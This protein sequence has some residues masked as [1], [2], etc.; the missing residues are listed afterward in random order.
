MIW[1]LKR[2]EDSSHMVLS[3]YSREATLLF[4]SVLQVLRALCWMKKYFQVCFH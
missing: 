4:V 2:L 3:T 1:L